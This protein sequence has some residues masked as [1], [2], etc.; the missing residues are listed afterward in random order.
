[1]EMAFVE[2]QSELKMVGDELSRYKGLALSPT[3]IKDV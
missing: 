2:M 3:E 1:M